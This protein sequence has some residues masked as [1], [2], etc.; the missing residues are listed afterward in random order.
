MASDKQKELSNIIRNVHGNLRKS[1]QTIGPTKAWENHLKNNE[2]L[3]L[4]ANAMKNLADIWEEN[5][6]LENNL[7]SGAKSRIKWII[8]YC[9]SYFFSHK[10]YIEKR[11]KEQRI[12]KL[13]ANND[14]SIDNGNINLNEINFENL[15]L[16]DDIENLNILDVGSCFSPFKNIE[17][18]NITALDLYPSNETVYK[19][20]FL[21]LQLKNSIEINSFNEVLSLPKNYFDCVIFSLLLEYLP[22]SEQRIECCQKAYDVLKYEGILIIITPDSQHV[23]KNAKLMKNWRYTLGKIGFSRIKFDKLSH[24]TCLVFR[25][26]LHKFITERWSN[27]HKEDYMTFNIEIPQD[28]EI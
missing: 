7:N 15:Y 9:I 11:L 5:A 6:L 27:I 21:K 26:S 16:N 13:Y 17:N 20:D 2:I 28:K 4:Y 22:S 24:I 19:G 18:F 3:Q 25:K 8:D 1:A 14:D 23:G 10:I 12:L